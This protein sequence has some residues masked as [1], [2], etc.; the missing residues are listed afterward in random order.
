LAEN[1]LVGDILYMSLK[2]HF[3]IND[4]LRIDPSAGTVA[5]SGKADMNEFE[6]EL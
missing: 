5:I 2:R 6:L 3:H 4:V 1:T